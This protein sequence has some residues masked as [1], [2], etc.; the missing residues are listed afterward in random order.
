MTEWMPTRAELLELADRHKLALTMG[1]AD[2]G[3]HISDNDMRVI[4]WALRR[5]IVG[6]QIGIK[7]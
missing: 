1:A 7:R 6:E 5:A 2:P 3:F 4:E